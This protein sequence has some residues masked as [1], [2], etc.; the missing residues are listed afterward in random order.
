MGSKSGDLKQ[1]LIKNQALSERPPRCATL[2]CIGTLF[3]P[4][5]VGLAAQQCAPPDTRIAS[6][7]ATRMKP[8]RWAV[9]SHPTVTR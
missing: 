1:R 4:S 9:R 6:D 3:R 5:V 8:R 2:S 7:T